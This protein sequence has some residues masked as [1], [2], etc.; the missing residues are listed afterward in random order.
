MVLLYPH[1]LPVLSSLALMALR[2]KGGRCGG[3]ADRNGST[4]RRGDRGESLELLCTSA[5][6]SMLCE[7]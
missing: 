4:G 5:V 1:F 6:Q 2:T 3:G 7:R